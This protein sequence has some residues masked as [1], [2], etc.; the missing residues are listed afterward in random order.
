ME[1]TISPVVFIILLHTASVASKAAKAEDER[2]YWTLCCTEAQNQLRVFVINHGFGLWVGHQRERSFVS[3]P[4]H[5]CLAAC[6]PAL[7]I[8]TFS[9]N[10]IFLSRTSLALPSVSSN[11]SSNII[12]LHIYLVF[13]LMTLE[14]CRLVGEGAV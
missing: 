10:L 12:M 9:H 3:F 8:I 2:V 13:V 6:V 7:C 11:T 1:G 4:P 14:A 5:F